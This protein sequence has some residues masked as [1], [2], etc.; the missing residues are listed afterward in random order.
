MISIRENLSKAVNY[1]TL[2]TALI[3]AAEE[4]GLK[5]RNKEVS[6]KKGCTRTN[7]YLR[8]R[9]FS[10]MEVVTHNHG[11]PIDFFRVYAGYPFGHASKKTVE[12]YIKRV[13]NYL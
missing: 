6:E 11:R 8:G 1:E 2:E 9:F 7:F 13:Q 3:K 10:S 4:T 12:A 5:I